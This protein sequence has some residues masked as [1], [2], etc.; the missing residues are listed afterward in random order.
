GSRAEPARTR[1]RAAFGPVLLCVV[2]P[3][4]LRRRAGHPRPRLGSHRR[5]LP[6][7]TTDRPLRPLPDGPATAR[8]RP[9]PPGLSRRPGPVTRVEWETGGTSPGGG[10]GQQ[11][12]RGRPPTRAPPRP[13]PHST[14]ILR[15]PITWAT[16]L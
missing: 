10:A 6:P 1:R 2:S 4:T 12:T 8:G 15:P 13:R 9:P 3:E 7:R 16:A 14:V 5:A 11:A